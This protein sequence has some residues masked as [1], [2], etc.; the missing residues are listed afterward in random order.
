MKE[1]ENDLK[2]IAML[3]NEV[4]IKHDISYLSVSRTGN[5]L[6]DVT[7]DRDGNNNY[8]GVNY[9]AKKDKFDVNLNEDG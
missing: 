7:I 1:L 2:G 9:W 5:D 3:V 8:E 4:A 6:T